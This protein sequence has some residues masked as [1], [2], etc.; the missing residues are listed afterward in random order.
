MSSLQQA[1]M[2]PPPDGNRSTGTSILI[3]TF[4]FTGI[5]TIVVSL[6]IWT[7]LKI[8]RQF[9]ADDVLTILALL[10][11]LAFAPVITVS[12]HKG[13]GKHVFY[14]TPE[15]RIQSTKLAILSNPLVF[16][17]SSFPNVSVAIS[18]HRIL[19]PKSWQ[20]G[21]LYGVPILQSAFALICSIVTYNECS[22][23]EGLWNPQIPH[24]CLPSDKL[25]GILYANGALSAFTHIFLAVVPIFGLWK[26]RI[27]TKTKVGV[28]LLMSTTAVA[29]IAAIIRTTYISDPELGF[30]FTHAVHTLLNWAII[31][32][33]F[34]IV[35][36]CIP[37]LRPFIRALN[38][39]L[40][41][42]SLFV[43][44][45]GYYHSH[46]RRHRPPPLVPRDEGSG[47]ASTLASP[48]FKRGEGGD[49]ERADREAGDKGAEGGG[50]RRVRLLRRRV[51]GRRKG[52]WGGEGFRGK[53]LSEV[54]LAHT[55]PPL[56]KE[57]VR[58]EV[59]GGICEIR[60]SG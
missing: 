43:I 54:F 47:A 22:P 3:I 2:H 41:I 38:Q 5:S 46:S 56:V 27:K 21:F 55:P 7:R 16:L 9:G 18:V 32:A 60:D 20:L 52:M 40:H 17:A 57:H 36:A 31:E 6:K 13:L 19:V 39:K 35:A 10:F 8:I 25:V 49:L 26:I 30:D 24:K 4:L 48:S 34:I 42:D 1:Y 14:L 53:G 58:E 37:S 59:K 51:F 29:A 11:L 12:V 45:K 33:A 44:P 50:R 15:A 23:L 28:C